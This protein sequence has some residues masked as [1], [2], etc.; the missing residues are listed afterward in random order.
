MRNNWLVDAVRS[1]SRRQIAVLL[2][3]VIGS[4]LATY[5]ISNVRSSSENQSLEENQRLIPIRTGLLVNEI[6][7]FGSQGTVEEVLVSE[8]QEVEEGQPLVRLDSE[9]AA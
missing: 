6:L 8:G 7:S 4:F 5:G 1:L 3:V 9:T 2:V